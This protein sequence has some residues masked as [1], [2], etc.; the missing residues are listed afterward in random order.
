MSA[1]ESLKRIEELLAELR[2]RPEEPRH[3]KLCDELD[4]RYSC[5]LMP[6]VDMDKAY[7]CQIAKLQR[8]IAELGALTAT[9]KRCCE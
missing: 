7:E 3:G 2:T 8:R 5:A 4:L 1:E 9:K 6:Y